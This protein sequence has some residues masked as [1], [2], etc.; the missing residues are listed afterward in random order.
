MS[1]NLSVNLGGINFKNP[2]LVGSGPT[3]KNFGQLKAAADSGWAG[4]SIKLAME[5]FPYLNLP[6]RYRWLPKEKYHIFTAEKRLTADESL[7]LM[8]ESRKLRDDFIVIPTFSFDGEDYE[9]W[10]KLANRFVNAGARIIELNMCCPNMSFNLTSTGA[11]TKKSTGASLGTDYVN[12]PK[13]VKIITEAVTVPVIV[14]FY[15]EGSL[16]IKSARLALDAGAAAVG[17]V[18]GILGIPDID[19]RNPFSPF[20]RLQDELTLGF[21]SGAHMRPLALKATYQM[22]SALGPEA[23][24]IGSGGITDL[25]SAVQQIM[26]GSDMVWICTETMIRG[27]DWMPKMLEDLE[28]Y[29]T[30]MGYK[31]IRDFRDILLKNIVSAQDLTIHKGYAELDETK[32]TSCGR[33]LK[34]PHCPALSAEGK[35]TILKRSGCLGCSTCVDVCPQKAFSMKKG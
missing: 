29:M 14:K 23:F 16:H 8:E 9:G 19:V 10:G 35:K 32:C 26:V 12:L 4:A 11:E 7:S 24:I 30:E 15:P 13:V 18:G 22:R 6:P 1:V 34:I 5:P 27:F 33:C 20:Y 28:K 21:M 31:S 3:V 2:F 17:H 25:N